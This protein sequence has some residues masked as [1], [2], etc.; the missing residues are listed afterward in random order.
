MPDIEP[1]A[2]LVA[3]CG[4]YCGACRFYLTGK[5]NGCRENSKASW[6]KV[7]ACCMAK[8]IDTCAACA[9]FPEPRACPKFN[10][11][12]SR[13]FGLVFR[14]DRAACIAQIK[15]LGRD[16]HARAMAEMKTQTIK[17]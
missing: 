3:C 15:R 16:G 14:S 6:C 11:F 9:E 7:R 13:L 17:R 1:N 12:M 4:L 2:E 10:N 8:R 5:C